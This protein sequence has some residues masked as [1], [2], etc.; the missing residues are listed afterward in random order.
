M[1]LEE[2][3]SV[4]FEARLRRRP[5]LIKEIRAPSTQEEKVWGKLSNIITK[6]FITTV[7]RRYALDC[8]RLSVVAAAPI[9]KDRSF[10]R[11][12]GLWGVSKNRKSLTTHNLFIQQ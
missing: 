8:T 3:I 2:K 5:I 6:I 11:V 10:T 7:S 4:V 1:A 9:R 12:C